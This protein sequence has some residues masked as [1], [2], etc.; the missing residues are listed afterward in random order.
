MVRGHDDSASIVTIVLEWSKCNKLSQFSSC[1]EMAKFLCS[2]L[3]LQ[4]QCTK[5]TIPLLFT[6][7]KINNY[8][9]LQTVQVEKLTKLCSNVQVKTIDGFQGQERE[10]IIFSGDFFFRFLV[11]L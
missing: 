11:G 9:R 6:W 10:I 4:K 8:D 5:L 2:T 1:L 7:R 3:Q